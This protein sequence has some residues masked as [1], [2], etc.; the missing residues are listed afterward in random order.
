MKQLKSIRLHPY[1]GKYRKPGDIYEAIDRDANLMVIVKNSEYYVEPPV[2]EV[3][4]KR[5]YTRKPQ[6]ETTTNRIYNR[7]DMKA[8]AE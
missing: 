4:P 6:T 5:T 7:K 1:G 2:V 8:E 3:K